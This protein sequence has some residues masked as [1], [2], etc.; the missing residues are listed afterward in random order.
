MDREHVLQQVFGAVTET[1]RLSGRETQGIQATTRP[2]GG[3]AGFDSLNGLE[4]VTAL[5]SSTGLDLP[6]DLFISPGG[7]RGL[8]IGEIADRICEQAGG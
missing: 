5:S 1:Q 2:V 7:R 6:D 4:A 3:L 8:S